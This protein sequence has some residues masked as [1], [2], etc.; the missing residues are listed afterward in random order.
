MNL[1]I[2]SSIIEKFPELKIGVLIAK[3]IN[4]SISNDELKQ[5]MRNIESHIKGNFELQTL[6]DLPFIKDWRNAYSSF[7]AK[8][9]TFKNSVE[10]LLRR[11]LKGDDLP[12]INTV[13][14]LYNLISVKYVVPAGGDD[15]DKVDG[16][17]VL[18]IAKG[19]E[20]FTLLGSMKK[21]VAESGEVIYR[22]N[23]EILC[24]RWN[25]SECDKTKMTPETKNVIIVLEALASITKERLKQALQELKEKAEK[26]LS[27]NCEI[28]IL[29]SSS[30]EYDF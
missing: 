28:A 30:L 11:I 6:V 4:N 29:D 7:G 16:D 8:P 21:E 18:T 1:K 20:Q 10:S 19:C 13:V 5:E 26:Y 23:K 12:D 17:I 24:R 2:D 15:I 22:D 3:N 27:A 9:K 14:N 25:W